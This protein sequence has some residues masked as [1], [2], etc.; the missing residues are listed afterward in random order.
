M[1]VGRLVCGCIV[2]VWLLTL[3]GCATPTDQATATLPSPATPTAVV[4]TSVPTPTPAAPD[5]VVVTRLSTT[6]AVTVT[7][8]NQGTAPVTEAFWVDVYFNPTKTPALN[9]PWD[10]IASH[11]AV[12]GVT[13]PIPA[14]SSL[15]LTTSGQ[16]YFGPPDSSALPLP[17][18]ANVYSLV[19]SV[20]YS[21][22]YGAVPESNEGNNLFGLVVSTASVAGGVL[23]EVGQSQPASRQGLPPRK[24]D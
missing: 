15:A 22:T 5:L 2:C 23:P 10:T 4:P 9:E 8:R 21:T 19:D 13:D 1:S 11:V 20:D 24:A 12:W 3:T 6:S 7:V 16:Y 14:G 18:V 17:V